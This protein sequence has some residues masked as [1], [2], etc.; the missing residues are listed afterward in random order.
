MCNVTL[1]LRLTLPRVFAFVFV[2]KFLSFFVCNVEILLE[3]DKMFNITNH[4]RDISVS[5]A[6]K[7]VQ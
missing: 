3:R 1:T 2:L 5:I 7:Y 6:C 4:N